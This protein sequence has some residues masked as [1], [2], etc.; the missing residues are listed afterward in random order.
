MEKLAGRTLAMEVAL[1]IIAMADHVRAQHSEV[2]AVLAYGSCLRGVATTESLIDLYVLTSTLNGVSGNALLRA[3]CR[4]VPP[5]VHF[6]ECQFQGRTYRAKYAVLP[7]ALFA[8]WMKRDNPY[9]WARFSQPAALLWASDPIAR[10]MVAKSCAQ[11][12][13]TMFANARALTDA[14]DP[15]DIWAA[16]FAATYATELRAETASRARSVVDANAS[17]IAKPPSCWHMSSRS[18]RSGACAASKA[19]YGPPCG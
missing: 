3:G 13:E 10:A 1:E 11:A 12:A 7:R 19:N 2:L 15:L 8:A 14:S 9:F 4:L 16:G 18:M 5:N 17:T 6:A